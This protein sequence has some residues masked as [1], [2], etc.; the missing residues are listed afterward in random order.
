[1]LWTVAICRT[2]IFDSIHL[3][4]EDVKL[5]MLSRETPYLRRLG[6]LL[7]H[8]CCSIGGCGSGGGKKTEK[9][10]VM[11]DLWSIIK[12]ILDIYR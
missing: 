12:E 8:L 1:M 11:G 10:M 6:T 2:R 5:S 3:L 7:F 4:Y 9:R